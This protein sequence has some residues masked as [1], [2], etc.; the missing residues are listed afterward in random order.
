MNLRR[1]LSA[2]AG[3]AVISTLSLAAPASAT[4]GSNYDDGPVMTADDSVSVVR[5][6]DSWISIGW[7]A[8]NGLE[9]FR[10]VATDLSPWADVSYAN[11]GDTSAGLMM[12]ADLHANGI[13]TAQ[14]KLSTDVDGHGRYVNVKIY[15]Q[16]D[17]NGRTNSEY[18]GIL[19]VRVYDYDGEDYA[20]ATE[21]AAAFA[22]SEA[23]VMASGPSANWIDMDFLGLSPMNEDFDVQVVSGLPEGT[24]LYPQETFTSLHHDANLHHSE[25][26]TARIWIDPTAIEAGEYTITVEVAYTDFEG[27]SKSNQHSFDLSVTDK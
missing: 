17:E 18:M 12:G 24:Y 13:D 9:N 20:W 10:M 27:R 3:A 14:F 21:P 8:P 15:A 4:W 23:E 19:K 26:D 22:G 25:Q 6:V 7:T 5:G 11:E 2:T 1:F 16:W